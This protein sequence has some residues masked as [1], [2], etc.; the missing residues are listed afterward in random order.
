[1]PRKLEL[2]FQKGSDGRLGR[3]RKKYLGKVH[4]LGNGKS[5]SDFESYKLA[6]AKWEKLKLE[7]EPAVVPISK[8]FDADYDSVI[9]EWELALAWA[10][11]NNDDAEAIVA[12]EKVIGLRQRKASKTQIPIAN[13]DRVFGR[14]R[15]DPAILDN[16]ADI[17]L[18]NV[19]NATAA[20]WDELRLSMR[21]MTNRMISPITPVVE[22]DLDLLAMVP[23]GLRE[24]LRWRD[25]IECQRR[26]NEGAG[27]D[28]LV[29]WAET[30]L[31]KQ[32][33]RCFAGEISAGRYNAVDTCTKF[34][35]DWLGGD[36]PVKSVT[37][38]TLSKYHT[39]LLEQVTAGSCASGYALDR[40]SIAKSLIRW[41]WEQDAIDSLPK[42]ITSSE[43]RI[44]RVASTPKV[45]SIEE[46][47]QL[48]MMSTGRTRLYVLL[49][50]NTGMT[51][52]DIADL[53]DD[54]VDWTKQRLTRKRS[55]T[56]K[57]TGVPTVTYKLWTET[58]DLL[59]KYRSGADRVLLNRQGEPLHRAWIDE[60]G[61]FKKI[62]NI[63]SAYFRLMTKLDFTKPL[64]LLRK[65]S[66]SLIDD[67]PRFRGLGEL[68][69]GH[70]PNTV[71]DK[72]YIQKSETAL[73]E[74]IDF[75]RATYRIEIV[76]A[77]GACHAEVVSDCE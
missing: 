25:R 35:R 43:L 6:Y 66:P 38:R 36:T 15:A 69:L 31:K 34:F 54:Q 49:A 65:T 17:A 21:A 73:D 58:F 18:T 42:N 12:R 22:G 2:T 44:S 47:G 29:A 26:L 71:A 3:W 32:R 76:T 9:Q 7:I 61:K 23:E 72:H 39:F 50:M 16:V 60:N 74:A 55:K 46:V 41:L 59:E 10:I 52:K 1:M 14:F 63:K 48:L 37:G 45:F 67:D 27:D 51:Q 56:Q 5:Q 13:E 24:E 53:R 64:K 57:H 8:P 11:K 62:D 19:K 33:E 4:Y 77:A 30:Y 68:F 40:M 20:E 75:L 70:A 28:T